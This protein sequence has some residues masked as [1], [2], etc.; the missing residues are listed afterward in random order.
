MDDLLQAKVFYLFVDQVKSTTAKNKK[1]FMKFDAFVE[2]EISFS[3]HFPKTTIIQI[4]RNKQYGLKEM[5]RDKRNFDYEAY[6]FNGRLTRNPMQVGHVEADLGVS[7]PTKF[8]DV[9]RDLQ[10]GRRKGRQTGTTVRKG[11]M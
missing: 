5:L 2:E 9:E 8:P 11:V 10:T 1:A 6:F 4:I 7:D 3:E